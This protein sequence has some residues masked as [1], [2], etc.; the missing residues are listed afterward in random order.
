LK[1]LEA[2]SLEEKQQPDDC[3]FPTE[4][5]SAILTK[6]PQ[7]KRDDF[8]SLPIPCSIGEADIEG[9]FRDLNTNINLM[10]LSLVDKLMTDPWELEPIDMARIKMTNS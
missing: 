3:I 6:K 4:G 10:T 1:K 7:Q 8:K 5:C 9:A 2:S